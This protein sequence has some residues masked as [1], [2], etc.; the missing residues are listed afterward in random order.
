M[1]WINLQEQRPLDNAK[2]LATYR[3]S[4]GKR[5]TLMAIWVPKFSVETDGDYCEYNEADDTH[6]TP[7]GWYECIEN[8][9]EHTA[10]AINEGEIDYWMMP[11]QFPN[12]EISN[13]RLRLAG[14]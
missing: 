4:H 6:Y 12:D 13:S 8:W 9:P 2:V 10:V 5:R 1:T 7:E 11:P 3:N 14:D